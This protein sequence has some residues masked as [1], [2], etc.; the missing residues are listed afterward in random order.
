MIHDDARGGSML[1]TAPQRRT[2]GSF[3]LVGFVVCRWMNCLIVLKIPSL[4]GLS[5]SSASSE[6]LQPPHDSP[7]PPPLPSNRR[8]LPIVL[9]WREHRCGSLRQP[10]SATVKS[11]EAVPCVEERRGE[12]V[13]VVEGPQGAAGASVTLLLAAV[14]NR[15]ERCVCLK[16]AQ[17]YHRSP[18]SRRR[19]RSMPGAV[20]RM[21][22]L[23]CTVVMIACM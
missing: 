23:D 12:V 22:V 21:Q 3:M 13:V 8:C 4:Q 10:C 20:K 18:A 14:H 5:P 9:S 16:I 19:S 11:Q 7:P 15:L 2:V 17:L 6:P 1:P